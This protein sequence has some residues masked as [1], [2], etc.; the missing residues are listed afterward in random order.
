MKVLV[1]KSKKYNEALYRSRLTAEQK[2]MAIATFITTSLTFPLRGGNL[3]YEGLSAIQQ[4]LGM[5]TCHSHNV[6]R[7]VVRTSLAGPALLGGL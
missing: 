2:R 6:H 4:P 3:K 1:A 5:A 7:N